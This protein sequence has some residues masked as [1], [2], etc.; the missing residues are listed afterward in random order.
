LTA[1]TIGSDVS[2]W[3]V[4]HGP[5]TESVFAWQSTPV[6][7]GLGATEEVGHELARLG[8]SRV[9]VVTDA[10]LRATGLPDHVCELVRAS[11]I[12]AQLWDGVDV[13]PTDVSIRRA[14]SELADQSFDAF[15]G[16]GGGSSLDT[17]KLI[18]LLSC[19]GE[20]E[21]FMA[22][23]HGAAM[24]ISAPLRPM[25]GVPTTA[26]TGS[27]CSAV[28]IVN[29]TDRHVKGAVSDLQL[30]PTVAVVDPLNT[31]SAPSWVT[32]S[33]GYDALVQTLESYT[34][35]PYN[36]RERS[37]NG[38][39]RPLYAGSTPISDVWNEKALSLLGRYLERAIRDPDDI[40]ART[41]MALGALF[42][43]MGTAGA[44]IPHSAAYAV[45]GLVESYRPAQFG[46][47]PALVP[48]GMS[49]VVT[50]PAA[51]DYTYESSP[52][53][54]ER[55]VHLVSDGEFGDAPPDHALGMWLRDLLAATGGPSGLDDFGFTPA[56]IPQLV[57]RTLTQARLLAGA[58]RAVDAETLTRIFK[59]SFSK[60]VDRTEN[61]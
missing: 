24:P 43:R 13:E 34:S 60:D 47:G 15:I 19:G 10:G 32:A 53:R 46:P 45:A 41:G 44:H 14:R 21:D 39:V 8:A 42:S 51:L 49:V 22:A 20:L 7:F 58:P 59:A 25:I 30:R 40:D 52:E 17:C 5:G 26:G 57:A 18:N 9:L 38:A 12:E 2:Q 36:R 16:V 4:N 1:Q 50:A 11:S 23:P 35:T 61:R 3:T 31:V 54:H 56:D 29:L 27:E 37:P 55:A 28:A 48:H 6:R 33:A